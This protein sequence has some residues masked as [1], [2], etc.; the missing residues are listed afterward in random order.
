L[1]IA[2]ELWGQQETPRDRH[3]WSAAID[4]LL[5]AGAHPDQDCWIERP[6]RRD[7]GHRFDARPAW[8]T[9]FI[10]LATLAEDCKEH[11]T[12]SLV[13]RLIKAGWSPHSSGADGRAALHSAC[14]LG[15]SSV[16]G[17]LL[18]A[19]ANPRAQDEWG[20]AP[21]DWA[22]GELRPLLAAHLERAELASAV[23]VRRAD[24]GRRPSRRI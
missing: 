16:V 9:L 22:R 10:A 4:D 19:G 23:E 17:L 21:L 12:L 2:L 20:D 1:A 13:E 24:T 3:L 18:A 14:V 5:V 7:K 15:V 8:H 6:P 11:E